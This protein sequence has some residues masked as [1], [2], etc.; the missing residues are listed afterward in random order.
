MFVR[1]DRAFGR[2]CLPGLRA[3]TDMR[4][5]SVWRPRWHQRVPLVRDAR[6]A[7]RSAFFR[8][9]GAIAR[10]DDAR[11]IL[12]ASVGESGPVAAGRTPRR[13]RRHADA[14][15]GA[16]SRDRERCRGR[17]QG[18]LHHGAVSLRVN[19]VVEYLPSRRRVHGV[20][21]T[22]QRTAMVRPG[23]PR[24]PYRPHASRRRQLLDGIRRSERVARYHEDW[25][26]ASSVHGRG[27]WDPDGVYV[28]TMRARASGRCC[29]STGSTSGWRGSVTPFERR[30]S[31]TSIATRAISG[32]RRFGTAS[33]VPSTPASR[34]L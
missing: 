23:P 2:C 27:S 22:A 24:T 12:S 26:A 11:A 1:P 5:D 29:S 8:T 3:E 30:P 32:A 28:R 19:T 4:N 10:T 33:R 14:L 13:G 34:S 20:V 25:I 7:L 6:E 31:F 9:L 18:N 21:R 17:A 16:R 15:P